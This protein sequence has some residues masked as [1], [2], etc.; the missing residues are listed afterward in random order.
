MVATAILDFE[1]FQ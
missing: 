1:K